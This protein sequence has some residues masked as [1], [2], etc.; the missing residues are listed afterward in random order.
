[1]SISSTVAPL[2]LLA[3][4]IALPGCASLELEGE[5]YA[6]ANA[7]LPRELNK[8]TLPRY[9]VEPPDILLIESAPSTR[10]A[11]EPLKVGEE[12]LVQ[13]GNGI[14]LEVDET[15]PPVQAQAE[16]P[17]QVQFRVING[18]YL[19]GPDGHIDLGPEYGRIA[20][21]G[22]TLSQAR[23]AVDAHLRSVVQ[24]LDPKVSLQLTAVAGKQPIQGEHLVRPDGTISLG[25]HGNLFVAGQTLDQI[26]HGVEELLRRGGDNDPM[27]TVD[28]LAY[29][30]KVVYV[31]MDG[32]GFGEQVLRL[33]Y[34]GN[35]TVL[36][37]IAQ[38]EGLSQVSSK[39]MWVARPA[40]AGTNMAQ[41]LDVHWR[42]IT[43]EGITT[44][45]HQLMPG[46]RIYVESDHLI[47]FDNMVSKLLNPVER[48]FGFVLLGTGM[49]RNV[50]FFSQQGLNGGGF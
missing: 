37:A 7:D 2:L 11:S 25:V 19:I 50:R 46:D 40:P 42:A 29:N 18:A 8:V 49:V 32:G 1:M 21:A 9:R 3:A 10:T 39:K 43:A 12:L 13:I 4:V 24:L 20:I 30:S 22:M 45:N 5:Y 23:A 35:E 38:V 34:T 48:V 33:P 44:T 36:D 31:I 6:M 41:I 17:L 16:M 15:L 14:P 27:V 47:A 28:V 26:K